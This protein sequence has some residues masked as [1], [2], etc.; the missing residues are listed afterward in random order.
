VSFDPTQPAELETMRVFSGHVLVHP[1]IDGEDVGWFILDTGAGGTCI[2]SGVA[3]ELEL[4]SF[5]QVLAVGAAGKTDAAFRRGKLFELGR[6]RFEDPIYVELDLEFLTAAFNETIAGIVGY[7]VFARSLVEFDPTNGHASLYDPASYELA[8]GSWQ[9]LV[10]DARTPAVQASFEGDHSAY[11]RLDT[12]AGSGNVVFHT[13]TVEKLGLL[14]DRKVAASGSGGVG[15]SAVTYT[16]ELAWFELA[17]QRFERPTVGF[18]TAKVGGLADRYTAGNLGQAFLQ[19]FT[20]V[21]DY[22]N[23]RIAFVPREE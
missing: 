1:T 19:P 3:D 21:L 16:G 10:L 17:G 18:A 14:E 7:D 6:L 20:L 23:E 15:G 22:S 4:P 11:F 12:G 8:R 2:D 9:P 13:P 5:G